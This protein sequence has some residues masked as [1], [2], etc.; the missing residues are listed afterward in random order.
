MRRVISV[1][2]PTLPTDRIR[3]RE[4]GQP[5]TAR[6]TVAQTGNRRVLAAVSHAASAAGLHSNMALTDARVRHPELVEY[7]ADPDGD[8]KELRRLAD[9]GLRYAPLV[10]LDA[11]DGLWIDVTGAAHLFGGERRLLRDLHRAITSQGL[12]C[13]V[14]IADTPGLAHAHARYGDTEA[15]V[16]PPNTQLPDDFPIDCLRLDPDTRAGL[17]RLGIRQVRHIATIPRGPVTRRFGRIISLRLDQTAGRVFEPITPIVPMSAIQAREH[18][19]EPLLTAE[20]FTIVI[21]SLTAQVCRSLTEA[22]QGARR[23]DLLFE[24]VDGSIQPLRIGTARPVRDPAHLRR[25]LVERLE[26]VDPGLGVEA[27]RLVVTAADR[28]ASQQVA[29]SLFD[30]ADTE[31]A[32][33]LDR[34]ANRIGSARLYRLAPVASRIPERSVRRVP[35]TD[36]V[37]GTWPLHVS[38]PVRLLDPPQIIDAVTVPPHHAPT[39]FTWRRVRHRVRHAEGPERIGGEW[40]QDQQDLTRDYFHVE[41]EQGRR[42]WLFRCP[43]AADERWFLHGFV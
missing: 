2:L 9:W 20:A 12:A 11:P 23:L 34:L 29:V 13:R 7:P 3:L 38:R 4:A 27:M 17:H 43:D 39:A 30:T 31:L 37:Q 6:V 21:E 15:T 42:Y 33:L 41:D 19:V 25:M 16:V 1:W 28:H 24:R 22:G 35:V 18:F 14:A 26:R 8:A 36:P 5:D 40:W 32:P 10:G